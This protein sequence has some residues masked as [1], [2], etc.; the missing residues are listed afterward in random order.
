MRK[1]T[2]AAFHMIGQSVTEP[3]LCSKNKTKKKEKESIREL[4][5]HLEHAIVK[6]V[7]K[8]PTFLDVDFECILAPM[9]YN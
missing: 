9:L 7:G 6:M 5:S 8:I 4:R 3:M 1:Q 2:G